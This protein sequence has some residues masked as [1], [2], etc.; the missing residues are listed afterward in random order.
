MRLTLVPMMPNDV[1]SQWAS[2]PPPQLNLDSRKLCYLLLFVIKF[3]CEYPKQ[4]FTHHC[5]VGLC[6]EVVTGFH[7]ICFFL[8][9]RGFYSR[10][11][12]PKVAF[13]ISL[14]P[15]SAFYFSPVRSPLYLKSNSYLFIELRGTKSPT[16]SAAPSLRLSPHSAS[17]ASWPAG[18]PDW[19]R[20]LMTI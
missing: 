2:N 6:V 14:Q 1:F 5:I 18:Q 13:L 12:P 11:P 10:F 16:H 4:L 8:D 20:G 7:R 9:I 19:I 17:K 3:K 15:C